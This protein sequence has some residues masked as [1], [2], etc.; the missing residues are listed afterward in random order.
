MA[1]YCKGCRI[2]LKIM[3]RYGTATCHTK[4]PFYK[5]ETNSRQR[6]QETIKKIRQAVY[7]TSLERC[8]FRNERFGG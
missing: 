4:C 1:K 2:K 6:R 3:Q 8:N 7:H 5:M